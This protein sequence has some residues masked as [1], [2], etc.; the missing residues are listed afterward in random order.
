MQEQELSPYLSGKQF[1]SRFEHTHGTYEIEVETPD[2]SART[3]SVWGDWGPMYTVETES[4][5]EVRVTYRC[6]E[7]GIESTHQI[8]VPQIHLE[9]PMLHAR[10]KQHPFYLRVV[11]PVSGL[12][13]VGYLDGSGTPGE[14]EVTPHKGESG[15][16]GNLL[17]SAQPQAGSAVHAA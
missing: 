14:L 13:F 5:D 1:R 9:S 7:R 6:A 8:R 4:T 2:L 17:P 16:V 11:D 12:K 15:L 10:R 3:R